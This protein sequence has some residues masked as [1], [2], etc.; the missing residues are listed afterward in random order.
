MFSNKPLSPRTPREVTPPPPGKIPRG[1]KK[2]S[3]PDEK[4]GRPQGFNQVSLTPVGC[5]WCG[6]QVGPM[7]SCHKVSGW[8]LTSWCLNKKKVRILN[9]WRK[10]QYFVNLL[11]DVFVAYYSKWFSLDD[12]SILSLFQ[13][14]ERWFNAV[15]AVAIYIAW[16]SSVGTC[17]FF[18]ANLVEQSEPA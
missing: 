3:L 13:E 9:L 8:W 12:D 14:H 4:G 15:P 1:L 6:V 2:L 18:F 10:Y 11:N 17:V 16:L 5:G 7:K